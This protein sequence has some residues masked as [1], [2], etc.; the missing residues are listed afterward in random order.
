MS[1]GK[2]IGVLL[3]CIPIIC[4]QLNPDHPLGR[5]W[6]DGRYRTICLILGG[7]G[8]SL[9][10]ARGGSALGY[11]WAGGFCG[12]L[13]TSALSY[14]ASE[15]WYDLAGRGQ[16]NIFLIII[17]SIPGLIVY[18][19]IKRCSDYTFPHYQYEIVPD[20]HYNAADNNNNGSSL[21]SRSQ[22]TP[23]IAY[24]V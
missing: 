8:G 5:E 4:L 14:A 2:I 12:G 10:A 6:E 23:L 18:L 9:M 19:I 3:I 20:T 7:I 15:E 16:M 22:T 17:S 24:K 11:L 1:C 21:S 13:V